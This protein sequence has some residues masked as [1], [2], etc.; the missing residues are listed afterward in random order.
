MGLG[1][2]QG[3]KQSGA[4]GIGGGKCLGRLFSGMGTGCCDFLELPPPLPSNK[5]SGNHEQPL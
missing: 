3:R 4:K 2:G 5:H 1:E